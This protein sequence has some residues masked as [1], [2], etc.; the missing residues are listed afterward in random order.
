MFGRRKLKKKIR[1]LEAQV[2]GLAE[3][4]QRLQVTANDATL[5]LRSLNKAIAMLQDEVQELKGKK[6][7]VKRGEV[8]V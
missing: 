8:P 1:S 7:L 5:R 6:K 3:E 2:R 4:N